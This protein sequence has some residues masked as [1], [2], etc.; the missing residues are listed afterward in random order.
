M[1]QSPL[2]RS[3]WSRHHWKDLFLLQKLSIDDANF[4]QKWW[5]QKWKKG[6]GSSRAVTGGTGVNG[7]KDILQL[8]WAHHFLRSISINN[9]SKNGKSWPEWSVPNLNYKM[10]WSSSFSTL[11]PFSAP[12]PPLLTPSPYQKINC[13]SSCQSLYNKRRLSIGLVT[14]SCVQ[15]D[16]NNK[17]G[18]MWLVIE[19]SY[20]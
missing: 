7:L 19:R 9:S 6:Q 18:T 13:A 11:L 10:F 5:R 14:S 4:G 16:A 15:K 12:L 20:T 17:L 1:S 3:L 8:S 2:D